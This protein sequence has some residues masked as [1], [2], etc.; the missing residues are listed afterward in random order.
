[1]LKIWTKLS[2]TQLNICLWICHYG[3][4]WKCNPSSLWKFRGGK[5]LKFQGEKRKSDIGNLDSY[6]CNSL[7]VLCYSPCIWEI[8]WPLEI[9]SLPFVVIQIFVLGCNLISMNIWGFQ[10]QPGQFTWELNTW[11]EFPAPHFQLMLLCCFSIK[12][13]KLKIFVINYFFLS[14]VTVCCCSQGV[15]SGQQMNDW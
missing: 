10:T 7:S 6:L 8:G 15:V 5:S 13:K 14:T 3:S 4:H 1:M 11:S 2:L 12:K 9:L